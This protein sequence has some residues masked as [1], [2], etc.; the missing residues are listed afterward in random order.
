MNLDQ[1]REAIL[2]RDE[3]AAGTCSECHGVGPCPRY[4][5]W[6]PVIADLPR[7]EPVWP[8]GDDAAT[9]WA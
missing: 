1:H 8:G 2:V 3:H 5:A 7:P 6:F 9:W 4:S